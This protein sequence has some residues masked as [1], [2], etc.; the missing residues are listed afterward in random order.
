MNS[1]EISEIL[2][3]NDLKVF[4]ESN[5]KSEINETK[6]TNETKEIKEIL[7]ISEILEIHDHK[8]LLDLPETEYLAL[9]ALKS[10]R[11]QQ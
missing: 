11:Q 3:S 1:K 5:E 8:G 2:E 9:R 6:E 7:E 4:N 10:E